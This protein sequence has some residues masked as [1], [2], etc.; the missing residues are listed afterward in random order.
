MRLKEDSA[1][2]AVQ[3]VW[4][5]DAVENPNLG[6]GLDLVLMPQNAVK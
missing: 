4:E 3:Q 2:Q 6:A 5:D 1:L